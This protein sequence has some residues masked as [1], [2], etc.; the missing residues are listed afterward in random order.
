M[1]LLFHI[2]VPLL[3][4]EIFSHYEVKRSLIILSAILPDLIDKPLQIFFN[5]GEGRFIGHSFWFLYCFFFLLLWHRKPLVACSI[6]FA[7]LSHILL[8][9]SFPYYP[10]SFNLYIPFSFLNPI[11]QFWLETFSHNAIVF[12]TEILGLFVI[13]L[14]YLQKDAKNNWYIFDFK[15]K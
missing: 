12:F 9:L 11:F 8:D 3:F 1:F 15:N 10:L 13:I 7:I 4:L 14:I 6:A 2:A 5:I